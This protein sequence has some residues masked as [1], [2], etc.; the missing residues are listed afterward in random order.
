[1]TFPVPG[2]PLFLTRKRWD[3]VGFVKGLDPPAAVKLPDGIQAIVDTR[4]HLIGVCYEGEQGEQ[5]FLPASSVTYLT[6]DA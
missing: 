4:G 6:R 1:M 3:T 2:D 5:V